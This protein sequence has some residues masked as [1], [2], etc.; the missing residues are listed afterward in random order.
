VTYIK[1]ALE[2][3]S[4]ISMWCD[5]LFRVICLMWARKHCTLCSEKT[6]THIVFH[7]SMNYLWI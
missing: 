6:P 1:I 5:T 4:A 3:F 2:F 7:I